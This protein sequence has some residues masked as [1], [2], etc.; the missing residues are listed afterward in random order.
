MSH[1]EV[2]GRVLITGAA[3]GIGR[4]AAALFA[5]RGWHCVLVDR[6]AQALRVTAQ[7]LPGTHRLETTDLSDPAQIA[8]LKD[9]PDVLDAVVNNAGIADPS[10]RRLVDQSTDA[11]ALMRAVNLDAPAQL[12]TAVM[13][14]L[15]PGA[16]IVNVS[17]NAGLR[18]IPFRG[19]YSLTKAGLIAQ[20]AALSRARPDLSVSV[21]CP[22]FTRTELNEKLV[23]S[24][25]LD[26]TRAA[27]K[28]PLGRWAE[29]RELAEAIVFLASAGARPL[30]GQVLQ[31]D[32]GSGAYGGS[33]ACSPATGGPCSFDLPLQLSVVGD[34]TG[35][36]S[37]LARDAA[38]APAYHALLDVHAL[39]GATVRSVHAAGIRFAQQFE[40]DAALTFLLPAPG[41]QADDDWQNAGEAA[42]VRMLVHTLACELAP[43]ALR[44]NALMVEPQTA[45]AQLRALLHYVSGAAAQFMTGQLLTVSTD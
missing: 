6:D 10:G 1:T 39:Q 27:A 4:A 36:W 20:S 38:G 15:A 33:A 37:A 28:I 14:R 25:R 40:R 43:R 34:A 3:S 7:A 17:S 12:V 18:C 24:G 31:L 21:L 41:G 16:R 2:P 13:G 11:Q 26:P 23:E 5:Q 8:A 29:P 42:A 35:H 45:P 44:V 19:Y 9:L 32:G 30:R 22:G